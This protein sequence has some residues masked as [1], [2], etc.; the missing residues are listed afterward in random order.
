MMRLNSEYVKE[1]LKS[2]LKKYI[3][4]IGGEYTLKISSCEDLHDCTI[5]SC[6]I[7]LLYYELNSILPLVLDDCINF[8]CD[9]QEYIDPWG[10]YYRNVFN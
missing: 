3:E 7:D 8:V 9:E 10:E 5:E 4:W 1:Y 2:E 6:E